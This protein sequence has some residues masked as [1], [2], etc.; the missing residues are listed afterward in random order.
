MKRLKIT[1]NIFYKALIGIFSALILYNLYATISTRNLFGILPILI[2]SVLVYFLVTKHPVSQKAIRIW[3]IV[4]FWGAQGLKIIGVGLQVLAESME[5][6]K[7]SIEVLTS[8]KVIY[9][10]IALVAGTIIWILNKNF[11]EVVEEK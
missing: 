4:I 6:E 2:Q 5:R 9:F 7:G 8:E 10:L 11:G 3:V 1:D